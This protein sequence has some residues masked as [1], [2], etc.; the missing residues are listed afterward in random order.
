[1]RPSQ[2]TER[3]PETQRGEKG[4]GTPEALIPKVSEP[5]TQVATQVPDPPALAKGRG[6]CPQCGHGLS[7]FHY[8]ED[9]QPET[10][11]KDGC[12]CAYTV[13]KKFKWN[14]NRMTAESEDVVDFEE[15]EAVRVEMARDNKAIWDDY[16]AASAKSIAFEKALTV[17]R[18]SIAELDS[19]LTEAK[20]RDKI[21]VGKQRYLEA[22]LAAS[23]AKY[24]AKYWEGIKDEN[25]RYAARIAELNARLKIPKPNPFP[26]DYDA[27]DLLN[28][29]ER[30]YKADIEQLKAKLASTEQELRFD[31]WKRESIWEANL[32]AEKAKTKTFFEEGIKSGQRIVEQDAIILRWNKD[33]RAEHERCHE[34]E[35]KLAAAVKLSQDKFLNYDEISDELGDAKRRVTG[36]EADYHLLFQQRDA[37][38]HKLEASE[39][40]LRW[41]KE[42]INGAIAELP[43]M[44]GEAEAKLRELIAPAESSIEPVDVAWHPKGTPNPDPNCVVAEIGKLSEPRKDMTEW[45]W[46]EQHRSSSGFVRRVVEKDEAEAKLREE[47][48]DTAR[49]R[50]KVTNYANLVAMKEKKIAMAEER[51][52][53][54][55]FYTT[56]AA[57]VKR[58]TGLMSEAVEA[59]KDCQ[60]AQPRRRGVIAILTSSGEGND[61]HNCGRHPISCPFGHACEPNTEQSHWI[62]EAPAPEEPER[63]IL[64]TKSDGD[65]VISLLSSLGIG[66][67]IIGTL[68]SNHDI[69]VLIDRKTIPGHGSDQVGFPKEHLEAIKA[70]ETDMPSLFI[71]SRLY[72]HLDIFFERPDPDAAEASTRFSGPLYQVPPDTLGLKI[73]C[74]GGKTKDGTPCTAAPGDLWCIIDGHVCPSLQIG[75][76]P[77]STFKSNGDYQAQPCKKCGHGLGWHREGASGTCCCGNCE[78]KKYEGGT[79]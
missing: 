49:E 66:A 24:N 39:A 69:D 9:G 45:T 29:R 32:A 54:N 23:E 55:R 13:P 67:E 35:E 27:I 77:Q 19:L 30:H 38:F 22:K 60:D 8:D 63:K 6:D 42:G 72:G 71:I 61:C 4:V 17:A 57:Q 18:G 3:G 26:D 11:A 65:C 73:T 68:P 51:Q 31:W 41:L 33:W 58:L 48:Q 50:L 37:I 75:Q 16:K 12:G 78:C 1:M 43:D 56:A 52:E 7:V 21:H 40:A 10:C 59:C 64:Y 44:P 2:S 25:I 20:E 14:T 70:V 74:N 76:R 15:A 5:E 53:K 28:E 34:L 36:L 47:R 62:P 46:E 79:R